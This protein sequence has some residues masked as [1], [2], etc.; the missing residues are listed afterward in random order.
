MARDAAKK[1]AV[2]LGPYSLQVASSQA[3]GTLERTCDILPRTG[4][5]G[6]SFSAEQNDARRLFISF[7]LFRKGWWG[8]D[9][10]ELF[11]FHREN[12]SAATFFAFDFRKPGDYV[13]DLSAKSEDGSISY[14]G[15]YPITVERSEDDFASGVLLAAF[16]A[17][18]L[19][20]LW[21]LLRAKRAA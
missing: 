21:R 18:T 13:L 2:Q 10:T 4:R 20:A 16:T 3:E 6:F 8:E 9:D 15:R 5:T 14:A 17:A 12:N 7:R 1:C 19:I 11:G